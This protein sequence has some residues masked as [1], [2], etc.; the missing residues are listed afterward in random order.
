MHSPVQVTLYATLRQH[1][2]GGASRTVPTAPGET[3]RDVL[4]RL[5]VPSDEVKLVFVDARPATLDTPLKGARTL[6]LFPLIAGG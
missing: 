3:V 5:G 4:G 6:A 1:L 2:D